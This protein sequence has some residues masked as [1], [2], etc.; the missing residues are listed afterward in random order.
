MSAR[1]TIT[2]AQFEGWKG[3]LNDA[4]HEVVFAVQLVNQDDPQDA[5]NALM[6]AQGTIEAVA[7]EIVASTKGGGK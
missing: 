3:R 7:E 1:Q 6:T 5:L 2:D 4:I